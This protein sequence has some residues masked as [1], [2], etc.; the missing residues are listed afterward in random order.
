MAD[1]GTK[2]KI[3]AERQVSLDLDN[4]VKIEGQAV[5]L[6][7][8]LNTEWPIAEVL[9][10]PGIIKHLRDGTIKADKIV[11][12][13]LLQRVGFFN[14][15]DFSLRCVVEDIAGQKLEI[16][17]VLSLTYSPCLIYALPI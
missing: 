7:S 5:S 17:Q 3:N 4:N 14:K 11:K 6:T 16:E 9:E 15:N 8:L 13:K 12:V 1:L 10:G 2:I